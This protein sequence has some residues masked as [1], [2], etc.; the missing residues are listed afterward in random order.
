MVSAQCLLLLKD[1]K[2]IFWGSCCPPFRG[3][4]VEI[5]I[6]FSVSVSVSV[7][8]SF[9]VSPFFALVCFSEKAF[10]FFVLVCFLEKAFAYWSSNRYGLLCDGIFC[11]QLDH[12]VVSLVCTFYLPEAFLCTSLDFSR[13]V[14]AVIFKAGEGFVYILTHDCETVPL[15]EVVALPELSLDTFFALIATGVPGVNNRRHC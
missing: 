4:G 15:S 12:F 6:P 5:S 7:S 14:S 13:F 11:L 3:Q 9:S 8:V 10:A 1:R 2:T